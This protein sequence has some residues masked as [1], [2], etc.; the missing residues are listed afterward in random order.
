MTVKGGKVR[1]FSRI[2]A[3]KVSGSILIPSISSPYVV[4]SIDFSDYQEEVRERILWNYLDPLED[5][6][7]DEYCPLF[8]NEYKFILRD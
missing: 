8:D 1:P 5:V 4:E 2:R 3:M 7:W 6:K